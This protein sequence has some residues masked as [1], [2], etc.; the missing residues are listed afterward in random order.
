LKATSQPHRSWQA[1]AWL[2]A[3]LATIGVMVWLLVGARQ[4]IIARLSDPVAKAQ[5]EAYKQQEAL[6]QADPEAPVQRRLPKSE[7]PPALVLLRDHFAA[8]LTAALVMSSLLFAF[9]AFALR[10]ALRPRRP[11]AGPC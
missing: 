7:E 6:R 8:V 4:R 1:A 5:W 9:L 2:A 10:G 11:S 3:Y